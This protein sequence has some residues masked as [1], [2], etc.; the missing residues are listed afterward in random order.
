MFKNCHFAK[1][2][3]LGFYIL[4]FYLF[5][6]FPA[7]SSEID[8]SST[9]YLFP[10]PITLSPRL[11]QELRRPQ[12]V[13][14]DMQGN[15]YV[16]DSG[17]NRILKFSPQ[18]ELLRKTSGWGS[19]QDLLDIPLDITV[20]A[21]LNIFIADYQNGRIVRFDLNL[22]FLW[23]Q[24]INLL[25]PDWNYPVS[26]SISDWGDLYIL[27]ETTGSII[28]FQPASSNAIQF[29]SYR[30]GTANLIGAKKLTLSSDGTI[31]ILT[32]TKDNIIC[33]DRFGNFL[34][35]IDIPQPAE[36]ISCSGTYL[37]SAVAGGLSCQY[38][39]ETVRLILMDE[40][41]FPAGIIDLT[42]S[43]N[44]LILLTQNAPFLYL[45]QLSRSPARVE[46]R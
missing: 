33:Y 40:K 20:D 42:V 8:S 31:Y 32:N 1:L 41:K 38:K 39:K 16:V 27:E 35:E 45:Y 43:K 15:I 46:W 26:L 6:V 14:M 11:F 28:Q 19:Q 24:R 2:F 18:L 7:I 25:N 44:K 30:P 10:I 36:S 17:N 9:I 34:K 4:S 12:A 5:T 37:W 23:D 3:R 21:G 22:N 13:E 29:G